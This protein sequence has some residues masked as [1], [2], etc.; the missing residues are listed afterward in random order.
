[1]NRGKSRASKPDFP[2]WTGNAIEPGK[3]RVRTS[4]VFRLSDATAR[5]LGQFAERRLGELMEEERRA[6]RQG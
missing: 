1:M 3:L 4:T 6:G 2:Y 5:L